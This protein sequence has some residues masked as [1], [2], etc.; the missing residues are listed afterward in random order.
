MIVR[1]I[2]CAESE[3]EPRPPRSCLRLE[4]CLRKS[5]LADESQEQ[6]RVHDWRP[7][8]QQWPQSSAGGRGVGHYGGRK[9]GKQTQSRPERVHT[10]HKRTDFAPR[11]L[12]FLP[13]L[14][15]Q[16]IQAIIR[17]TRSCLTSIYPVRVV[18]HFESGHGSASERGRDREDDFA[19]AFNLPVRA[20]GLVATASTTLRGVLL[21]ADLF[22]RQGQA[23]R[24]RRG[25]SKL[26]RYR[27]VRAEG[28]TDEGFL[29][30]ISASPPYVLP[31]LHFSKESQVP[32]F[33]FLNKGSF[34]I[35]GY[36][37]RSARFNHS[38]PCNDESNKTTCAH[39][40]K[41]HSI[42]R[43]AGRTGRT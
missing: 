28:A 12:L 22:F 43:Q 26:E 5:D 38:V 8:V 34:G 42:E 18:F 27:T 2:M 19:P 14:L 33:W 15:Q 24:R 39:A 11:S 9:E 3:Q 41:S 35:E 16:F 29:F 7:T 13:R 20:G 37:L 1:V 25:D 23:S 21:I 36:H 30:I 31:H 6:G 40:I 4:E 17:S 10:F 32:F